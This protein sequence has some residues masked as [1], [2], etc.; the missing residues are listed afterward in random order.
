MG[1]AMN[2]KVRLGL[3]LAVLVAL[4]LGLWW[5]LR[6]IST[7]VSV[8]FIRAEGTAS[9]L[10]HAPRRVTA[11]GT[12]ALVT[13]ALQ[14]LLSGPSEAERSAGLVT[15]I[16]SGSRL[17]NAQMRNG[18][19]IVDFSGAIESGGGSAS[20]LARFWQIVYTATQFPQAPRVRI[21]IDGQERRAMGG[22]GVIIDRPIARPPTI[23]RF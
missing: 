16:P 18:L 3:A 1:V 10:Q 14:Q 8:Y 9:T 7:D 15:A 6:P 2:V 22:E 13:A 5:W 12:T 4:L 21:L 17:R 23:P 19:V 20:M 11:R